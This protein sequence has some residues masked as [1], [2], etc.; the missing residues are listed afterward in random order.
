MRVPV[1]GD[2]NGDE[3]VDLNDHPALIDCQAAPDVEPTPTPP[4]MPEQCLDAFD[5]D[6]DG[7]VDLNDVAEFQII[8]G[9]G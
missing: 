9:A 1:P 6:Y 3:A 8:F 2:F 7:D 5:L 4:T